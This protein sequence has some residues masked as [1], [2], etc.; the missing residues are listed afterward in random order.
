MV[1]L[2]LSP[3]IPGVQFLQEVTDAMLTDL[4][5]NAALLLF[6]SLYEGFGWPVIEARECPVP[7]ESFW[8]PAFDRRNRRVVRRGSVRAGYG[9]QRQYWEQ[10]VGLSRA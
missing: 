2:A 3:E 1:G 7:D 4:Y 10:A 9:A 5:R 8:P 6:P